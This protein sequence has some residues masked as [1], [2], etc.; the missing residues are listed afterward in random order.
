[1][2]TTQE[3]TVSTET[4]EQTRTAWNAIA[5]GYDRFVTSHNLSLA[6]TALDRVDVGPG[7]R[8]LD[9]A[10]GSGALA[11]PAARAGAR[12][13][14]TDIS[15][16]MIEHLS[17]RARQE[18]LTNLESRMM[19]GH[20]L[21]LEDETFDVAGSQFGV[22]L[23]PDLPRG[24]REMVRVVRPGGRV[25]MVAFGRPHRAEFIAF[26]LAALQAAV[27]DFTGL[28][29]DPP[30]LPFQVADP[31]RLRAALREAG[32]SDVELEPVDY[33]MEF[34]SA[35]QLW[36]T[37]TNSNPIGAAMVADLDEDRRDAVRQVLD[38][39]LRERA[40]GRGTAV[41]TARVHIAVG[42]K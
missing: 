2:S 8:L 37:M 35:Q 39:M 7:V 41:L 21:D 18:G 3:E 13:L 25:L 27:P 29:T 31:D 24:L 34:K 4:L 20:A 5:T 40:E 6:E 26:L 23:F 1:M 14:A 33:P 42:T 9:V 16:A 15:P 30:P 38:G 36:D 28:P 12:V 32:L 17:S 10:A 19:D 22:M 11:L